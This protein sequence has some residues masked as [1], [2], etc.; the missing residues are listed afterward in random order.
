MHNIG[1]VVQAVWNKHDSN[2]NSS[3]WWNCHFERCVFKPFRLEKEAPLQAWPVQWVRSWAEAWWCQGW[4]EKTTPHAQT[5]STFLS[6]LSLFLLGLYFQASFWLFIFYLIWFVISFYLYFFFVCLVLLP[7][8][9]TMALLLHLI[10]W[11]DEL[12]TRS[13]SS[14]ARCGPAS[15]LPGRKATSNDVWI[16]SFCG[17]AD[18]HLYITLYIICPLWQFYIVSLNNAKSIHCQ[19]S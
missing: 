8:G 7:A 9:L 2:S 1:L 19:G 10:I 5:F 4:A 11:V 15:M 3:L 18:V 13:S 16:Y 17:V 12:Q 14:G 6:I